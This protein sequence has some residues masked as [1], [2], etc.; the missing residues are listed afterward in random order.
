MPKRTASKS[1]SI[2]II[3]SASMRGEATQSLTY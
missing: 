3:G 2:E 1:R